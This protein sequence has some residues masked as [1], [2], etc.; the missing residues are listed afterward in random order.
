MNDEQQTPIDQTFFWLA[1]IVS[2]TL[3]VFVLAGLA[4]YFLG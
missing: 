4:G 2:T 3:T 1:C